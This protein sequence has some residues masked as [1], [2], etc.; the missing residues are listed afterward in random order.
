MSVSILESHAA[1][2]ASA[3]ALQLR[4]LKGLNL[5]QHLSI[6][7]ISNSD[8]VRLEDQGTFRGMTKMRTLHVECYGPTVHLPTDMEA[9]Q[10][11]E[12]VHLEFCVVPK[13]IFQLQNL[14]E[15]SLVPN[16]SSAEFRGFE[17][18][19]NLKKLHLERNWNRDFKE[20]PNEFG[21]A[22]TFPKLEELVIDMFGYLKSIPSFH[23]DAMP[24]LKCLRIW[25]RRSLEN[26]PEGLTKLRN[27]KE[28]EVNMK[29]DD[30]EDYERKKRH[31]WQGLK[32][33]QI[34][35]KG[36]VWDGPN[37]LRLV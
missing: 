22:G 32:D 4:D 13:W 5:L 27:L 34:K 33:R 9:M 37:K 29:V 12:I 19:P 7:F 14:M 11:L 31:Y 26:M 8:D 3:C 25:S 18:I 17:K 30:V 1:R 28:V 15:L 2:S 10:R 36:E 6:E 23:E 24:K 21:E 35:L 16:S 20:F